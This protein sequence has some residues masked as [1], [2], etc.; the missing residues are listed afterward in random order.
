MH[1]M[2]EPSGKG[3]RAWVHMHGMGEPSGKGY[4]AWVHMHGPMPTW[5]LPCGVVKLF[6]NKASVLLE[7]SLAAARPC[8]GPPCS[9]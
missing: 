4:R 9:S 3:Y 8:K 7:A 6:T 1:G 5:Y 2:G